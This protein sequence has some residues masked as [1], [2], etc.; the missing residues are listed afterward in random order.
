MKK[1]P[2]SVPTTYPH[3]NTWPNHSANPTYHSEFDTMKQVNGRSVS[4]RLESEQSFRKLQM[5]RTRSPTTTTA[6]AARL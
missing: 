2:L 4:I 3:T 5:P 6:L 1:L